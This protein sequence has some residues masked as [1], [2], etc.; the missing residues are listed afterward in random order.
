MVQ[1]S[2]QV[3]HLSY[4]FKQKMQPQAN[5]AWSTQQNRTSHR[6]VENNHTTVENSTV[7]YFAAHTVQCCQQYCLV[8]LHLIAGSTMLNNT[9][10]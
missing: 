1:T 2:S 8:L 10:E 7:Q 6:T 3:Y 4:T 9:K 5:F